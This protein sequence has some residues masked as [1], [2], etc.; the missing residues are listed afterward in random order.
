[1]RLA[2]IFMRDLLWSFN[3]KGCFETRWTRHCERSEAILAGQEIALSPTAPRNDTSPPFSKHPLARMIAVI[4][5]TLSAE[6]LQQQMREIDRHA[7]NASLDGRLHE[8]R[9]FDPP[10]T[11]FEPR[12][13]PVRN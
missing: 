11:D 12:G 7:V 4:V 10:G 8:I 13:F 2:P 1:M 9:V 6:R 5:R 3:A